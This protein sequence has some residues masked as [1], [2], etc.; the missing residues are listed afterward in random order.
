MTCRAL[1]PVLHTR[2][3]LRQKQQIRPR[4]RQV[5]RTPEEISIAARTAPPSETL[6]TARR[7]L[8][9]ECTTTPPLSYGHIE[10]HVVT[11]GHVLD[12]KQLE[13]LR[14]VLPCHVQ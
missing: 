7:S 2:P 5:L 13:Q 11:R 3:L 6:N 4:S 8:R 9:S 10:E 1:P 12:A 14:R